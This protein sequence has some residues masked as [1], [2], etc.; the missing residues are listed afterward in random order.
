M[1][2][3]TLVIGGGRSGKSSYALA[4]ASAYARKA[5]IATATACDEEMAKRIRDH[6]KE[7]GADFLT[8]EAPEDLAGAIRGL[9]RD[10]DAV[11]IDCL[12]VWLGN[13]MYKHGDD[14]AH[15]PEIDDFLSALKSIACDAYIVSNEVGLGIIPDNALAR[16]FRDLAGRLNIDVAR[17][18]DRV[19][20]LVCGIPIT[21][22][23]ST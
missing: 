9:P 20:M 5:F 23:E 21:I 7:R 1:S 22:K 19:V 2:L 11:V 8:I 18:A 10:I 6:Q 17:L 14:A 13:L 12:T 3:T 16:R 15:F 4:A